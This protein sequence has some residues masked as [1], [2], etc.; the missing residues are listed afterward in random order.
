MVLVEVVGPD[1]VFVD[2]YMMRNED[3]VGLVKLSE[4]QKLVELFVDN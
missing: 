4:L 3:W 2:G 1:H